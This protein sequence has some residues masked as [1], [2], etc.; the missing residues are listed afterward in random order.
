MAIICSGAPILG[1]IRHLEAAPS[2]LAPIT[3]CL[4]GLVVSWSI[5]TRPDKEPVNTMFD[6]AIDTFIADY[7]RP[8]VQPA[9]SQ[10][11][12]STSVLVNSEFAKSC[13]SG[14]HSDSTDLS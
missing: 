6:A 2:N 8:M 10:A 11:A 9:G 12:F 3:N 4:D 7:G 13:R 14:Q 1:C 5:G